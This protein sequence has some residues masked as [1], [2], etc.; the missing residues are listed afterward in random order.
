M[1]LCLQ[2][3][4]QREFLHRYESVIIP[5]SFLWLSP[6]KSEQLLEWDRV[7]YVVLTRKKNMEDAICSSPLSPDASA[8]LGEAKKDETKMNHWEG[9]PKSIQQQISELEETSRGLLCFHLPENLPLI[10]LR[11]SASLA[12]SLSIRIL[13]GIQS[14]LSLVVSIH[15]L[16][17]HKW[18]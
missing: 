7:R 17:L 3:T 16:G 6:A 13:E 4:H 8:H 14:A 12:V 18:L 15:F 1:N 9:P 5:W 11:L 10:L 2:Q